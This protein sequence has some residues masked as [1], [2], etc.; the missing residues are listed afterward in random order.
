MKFVTKQIHA[1]LDYANEVYSNEFYQKSIQYPYDYIFLFK[2]WKEIYLSDNERY[3]SFEQSI[4]IDKFLT[5]TY[6]QLGYTV[7]EVPYGTV[8]HRVEFIINRLK[9]SP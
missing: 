1:Y 4:E 3:E 2:P 8:E 7:I 6:V 9:T 5:K